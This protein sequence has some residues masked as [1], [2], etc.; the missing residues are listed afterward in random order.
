MY[1]YCDFE[2]KKKSQPK[3]YNV[4]VPHIALVPANLPFCL[5]TKANIYSHLVLGCLET[6][7]FKGPC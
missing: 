5:L 1:V 7:V 6:T 3:L 4:A 2:K